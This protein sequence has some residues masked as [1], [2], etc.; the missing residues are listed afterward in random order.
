MRKIDHSKEDTAEALG[1]TD[2]EGD[3]LSRYAMRTL[4]E[5]STTSGSIEQIT[6]KYSD[7][8]EIALCAFALGT[9]KERLK[10]D[11]VKSDKVDSFRLWM[12]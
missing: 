1:F 3:E 2:K 11:S 5:Q 8:V 9:I 7:P 10:G 4:Y 12:R 6:K